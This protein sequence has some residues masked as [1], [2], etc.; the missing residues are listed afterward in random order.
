MRVNF[1]NSNFI[2]HKI[3]TSKKY[4]YAFINPKNKVVKSTLL[5]SVVDTIIYDKYSENLVEHKIF[6]RIKTVDDTT[7]ETEKAYQ[8]TFGIGL[9]VGNV[10]E[11]NSKSNP[12]KKT[13]TAT[14]AVDLGLNYYREGK[15]FSMTNELHWTLSIQKLGITGNNHLE[16]VTDELLTLHDFSYAMSKNNSWNFNLI[17]KTNTSVFTIF[18]GS[19][20]KDYTNYGKIQSFLNPYEIIISPGIKYQP[21]D[22]FRLSIS[23]YSFSLYGLTNQEIANTGYYTEN[24]DS[25]NNYDM[26]LFKKLGAEINVWYDRKFKKWMEMQYRLSFSS[27]YFSNITKDNLVSGLFITKIKII[28]NVS[29]NHRSTLKGIILSGTFKPYYLQTILLSY[30]KTFY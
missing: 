1:K 8:Y 29:L 12:D 16:K 19:Y 4:S 10:L 28:K 25:N 15:R 27:D 11:F 14:S 2:Q 13:F 3:R 18:D 22:Y 20:F 17:A 9:N 21:N 23:P 24:Y 30:S 7:K 26:F 6:N 5:K